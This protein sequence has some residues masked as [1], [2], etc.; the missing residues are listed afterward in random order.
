[1]IYK[2]ICRDGINTQIPASQTD[3]K[4]SVYAR[5]VSEEIRMPGPRGAVLV[6]PGG[7]YKMTTFREGEPVAL[8]FLAAGYQAFVLN[9]S[10][11]PAVYPQALL[12]ASAAIDYIR[13]NAAGYNVDPNRVAVCGFSAGGHLAGSLGNLWSEPFIAETLGIGCGSNR[14]DAAI[15]GY[16]AMTMGEKGHWSLRDI[17]LNGMDPGSY[18]MLSLENSV[19]EKNPPAFIWQTLEDTGTV[20]ENSTYYATALH[21]KNIPFELH[22]FHG[23]PHGMVLANMDTADNPKQ[24]SPRI[25]KWFEL[26]TAW[27]EYVYDSRGPG[28]AGS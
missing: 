14:P 6:L 25:A 2:T 13:R 23:G 5:E 4:L 8:A 27:L 16:G 21:E 11:T 10:V 17:L 22:I 15:I 7:G 9:Y 18:P 26:C 20:L 19:N 24:L 28:R 12:E 1:M 3:I